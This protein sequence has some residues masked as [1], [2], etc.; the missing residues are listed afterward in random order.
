MSI[1]PATYIHDNQEENVLVMYVDYE[2][3]GFNSQEKDFGYA[4]NLRIDN[5]K[6]A[7]DVLIKRI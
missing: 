2:F 3:L 7:T 5:I 4:Q 6:T 1:I